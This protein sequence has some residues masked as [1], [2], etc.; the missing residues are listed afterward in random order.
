MTLLA[1]KKVLLYKP[2]AAYGVAPAAFTGADAIEV[3]EPDLTA[4]DGGTVS[5]ELMWPYF[6]ASDPVQVDSHVRLAF[7]VELTSGG[8]FTPAT[9]AISA[10]KFGGLLKACGMKETTGKAAVADT[11]NSKVEYAPE[12]NASGSSV[13]LIWNMDGQQHRLLGARGTWT[14][15]FASKEIPRIRFEFTGL[16]ASPSSITQIDPGGYVGWQEAVAGSNAASTFLIHGT[17]DLALH[18]L[19]VALGAQPVHREVVGADNDVPIT[20]RETTGSVTMDAEKLLAWNPFRLAQKA[21]KDALQLAHG[22]TDSAKSMLAAGNRGKIVVLDAPQ[23]VLSEPRY[24]DDQGVATIEAT[25]TMVPESG[26]DE[27]KLTFQ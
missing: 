7:S 18:R 22:F 20:G 12:T 19:S 6:G 2:E 25:L 13:T 21:T 23:V 10:P 11:N 16:W 14:L 24:G 5:R 27:V 4:L 1:M 15:E 8:G 26:N 9:E 17:H 3:H